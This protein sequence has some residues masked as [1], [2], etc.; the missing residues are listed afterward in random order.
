MPYSAVSQP[1]PRPARN[2]GTRSSRAAVHI[3]RVRPISIR[4][5]PGAVSTKPGV[6]RT[7]RS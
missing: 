5:A 2:G 3:T 4:T 7:G 1:W 6:M